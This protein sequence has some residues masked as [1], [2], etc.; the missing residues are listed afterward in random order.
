MALRPR[1]VPVDV[2]RAKRGPL[3]VAVEESGKTRVKDRY[4]VSAPATGS[5]SRIGLDPGDAVQEGD[6]VAE[7]APAH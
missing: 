5:L 7:I 2:A 4:V 1:P 3:V 6:T